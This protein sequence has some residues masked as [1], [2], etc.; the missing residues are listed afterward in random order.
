MWRKTRKQDI[1]AVHPPVEKSD[2]SRCHLVSKKKLV[3]RLTLMSPPEKKNKM[4]PPTKPRPKPAAPGEWTAARSPAPAG[5]EPQARALWTDTKPN[6]PNRRCPKGAC[7]GSFSGHLPLSLFSPKKSDSFQKTAQKPWLDMAKPLVGPGAGFLQRTM[8]EKEWEKDSTPRVLWRFPPELV[9]HVPPTEVMCVS[10][11]LCIN[12]YVYI[13][14]HIHIIQYMYQ[15][16]GH[17]PPPPMVWS[18]HSPAS[19]A[20]WG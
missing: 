9:F 19:S 11:S 10:K 17:V 16:L 12:M 4:S 18:P 7:S 14:I 5:K 2:P 6:H 1:H 13:Y 15:S 3:G 8:A 20:T